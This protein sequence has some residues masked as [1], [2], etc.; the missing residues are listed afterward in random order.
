MYGDRGSKILSNCDDRDIVIMLVDIDM[1]ACSEII[2][3]N[4]LRLHES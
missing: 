3:L 1:N 2:S 4:F